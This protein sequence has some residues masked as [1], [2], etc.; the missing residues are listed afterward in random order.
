MSARGIRNNNPVAHKEAVA[1]H[2]AKHREALI[3]KSAAWAKANPE[4]VNA[5]AVERR[6]KKMAPERV[7]YFN[8][9]NRA[10]KCGLEFDLTPNDLLVP[11]H[12]PVLGLLLQV[13]TGHARDC[14]PSVD[15]IDPTRGYVRGNVRVISHRANTIK[16]DSTVAELRAV[17]AYME[18]V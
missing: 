11:S 3:A 18:G 1:R 13:Q 12:C 4:R 9:K 17:I 5:T 14:S 16:S 7:L 10:I 15:R 2:Y 8:A 6:S